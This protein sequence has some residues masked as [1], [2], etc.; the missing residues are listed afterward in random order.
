MKDM[1]N[2]RK[3]TE[4]EILETNKRLSGF[5]ISPTKQVQGKN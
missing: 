1:E 2:I 5:S 4:D 3:Q